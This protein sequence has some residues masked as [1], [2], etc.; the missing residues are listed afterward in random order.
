MQICFAIK[1][2]K[3][4]YRLS[5]KLVKFD[6]HRFSFEKWKSKY[7]KKWCV[8][9]FSNSVAFKGDVPLFKFTKSAQL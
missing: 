7:K 4:S 8:G 3:F 2:S 9:V 6:F 5:L 1:R